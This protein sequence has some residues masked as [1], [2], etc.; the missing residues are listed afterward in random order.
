VPVGHCGHR[1]FV[2]DPTSTSNQAL[3]FYMV[4]YAQPGGPCQVLTPSRENVRATCKSRGWIFS[5]WVLDIFGQVCLS[6]RPLL[7]PKAARAIEIPPS[8]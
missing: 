4:V 6:Q 5:A 3:V 8:C 1:R 7:V 2:T